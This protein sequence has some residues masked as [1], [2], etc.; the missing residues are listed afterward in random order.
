MNKARRRAKMAEKLLFAVLALTTLLGCS[1]LRARQLGREGNRHFQEGDYRAA[2]EAYSASERLHP[3]AVVALNKGLACRQ[4]LLPGAKTAENARATDCALQAF[5]RLKQLDPKDPRA[6][7][8]YQQTLFDADR[9][10]QLVALFQKQLARMPDD[11]AAIN[12]LVQVYSRWGRWDEALR[13]TE[14]RANRRPKDAEAHYAVGVFIYNR[15]FEKGGGAEKS[16]FDPRPGPERKPQP[17][18][19]AGDI[20]GRERVELAELGIAQ[21]K[22]ALELRPGYADA[23][24][25]LGLLYR[26]ESFAY[27][28]DPA[29]WQRAVDEAESFRQKAVAAQAAHTDKH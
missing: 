7:Q 1:E 11:P 17:T 8:L 19:A 16:S 14:E 12:A 28:N 20:V 27:F 15:L 9:F 22:H 26:Q 6:D 10:E 21:L 5:T 13:W 25:Y 4:L 18:F 3:L 2:V 24:T 23:L 29:A